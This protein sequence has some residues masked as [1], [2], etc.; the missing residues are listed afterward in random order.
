MPSNLSMYT[1]RLG[2]WAWAIVVASAGLLLFEVFDWTVNRYYVPQG[3]SLLLRYKGPLVFGGPP[4]AKSGQFAQVDETGRPLEIG[5]LEEMRGPGRHFYCP[6]WW[7]RELVPD[8]EIQPGEVAIVASKLGDELPGDQF[9]VDGDMG[10][11]KHKGILR[12]VYGPG[13]YRVNPYGYEFR[14]VKTVQLSAG[15]QPK[16]AGWVNVPTGY[17]GVVTNLADNPARGFQ[18]GIADKILQ[19]GYYLVNPK[20]QQIDVI[21]VGYREKSFHVL[22]KTDRQKNPIYDESGEPV[23]ADD[24]GGLAFPSND[25]FTIHM[26]FTAIWGL[27]PE[28]APNAVKKLGVVQDVEDKVIVPQIESICRNRGSQLGA[29]ELLVGQTRQKFQDDVADEFHKALHNSDVSLK[30]GLI[31]YISIPREVRVPIQKSFIAD[32]LKLTRDQEQLTAKTEATLRESERKVELEAERIKAETQKMVAK[33]KAEGQK[34]A[35]ET[36]A[37][38]TQLVAAIDKDTANLEAQATILKGEADSTAQQLLEE[39][40]AG[41]FDLAVKA[42]GSGEAFNQWVFANGL[43]ENIKLTLFYAGQGTFW[44]DL[45]GFNDI[46]LGKQAAQGTQP[47]VPAVPKT[48]KP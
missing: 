22:R 32:E 16:V 8:Q 13:R 21:E 36:K 37:Q 24:P 18:T 3:F 44:T 29:V 46:L 1:Q 20:E 38:T 26:D 30:Y 28:Q 11:T 14:K 40:K 10:Q 31:R 19:P 25:G 41:K 48:T 33:V 27:M 5:I 9:L 17:V 2:K 47:P 45:K 39:A 15:K 43:P 12:K 34:K 35:E 6:I 42:F 23:L 7:E 4:S